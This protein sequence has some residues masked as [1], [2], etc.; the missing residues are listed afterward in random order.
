[1]D[2]EIN[3]QGLYV[4]PGFV[5]LCGSVQQNNGE[6]NGCIAS[7][8][9][10]AVAG[11]IT[12]LCCPP[13]ISPA[14]TS[15]AMVST[16]LQKAHEALAT[17]LYCI[18]AMSADLAGSQ[19]AE[20]A[21]L[22]NAGCIAV[23]QGQQPFAN[24]AIL[25]Q[26]YQY[27]ANFNIPVFIQP[28]HQD[29]AAGGV[30]HEGFVA[31]RLG[32]PAIPAV[33]ETLAVAQ[34]ILL[35]KDSGAVLH[36]NKLSVGDSVALIAAAQQQ[37]L[38]VTADVTCHHLVL[39]ELDVDYYRSQCHVQPPLRSLNDQALLRQG[40]RNKVI[41]AIVSDHQPLSIPCKFAPFAEAKSGISTFETLLPLA[42]RLQN[43]DGMS[44]SAVIAALTCQP[45]SIAGI[46]GGHLAAGAPAD[47]C[48]FD[49]EFSW[50]VKP[51]EFVSY[52]KNTPFTDWEL[53][54]K[55]VETLVAGEVVFHG[56]N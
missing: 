19:L 46:P 23:G 56:Q 31:T 4:C 13:D 49:P 37:G 10:A 36:F 5:D 47:I 12:S 41:G 17:R 21:A 11:G 14:I 26:C 16:L 53:Q 30:A 50:Q 52:G 28:Q 18:G 33:A 15:P 25:R 7:E 42:L 34:H 6:F 48:I 51:E 54:G 35:A 29:L 27:A 40:I 22:H 2:M 20:M 9:T 55:V 32:L 8:L 1:V 3:A 45:A 44:L 43:S 24:L 38:P 39:H